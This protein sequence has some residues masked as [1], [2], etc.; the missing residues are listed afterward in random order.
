MTGNPTNSR[1]ALLERRSAGTI[2]WPG[3]VAMLAARSL[4]AIA[5]QGITAFIFAL[6]GSTSPWQES[7]SWLPVY[8]TLVDLGCLL[9]L[10]FLAK[11]EGIRLPDLAGFDR[12]RVAHHLLLGLALVPPGLVLILAGNTASSL[13]VL[14]NADAPDV[15]APIP[16]LPA[17]YSVLIFPLLWAITEQAT[18][19]GYVL[20]RLEVLSSSSIVAVC[21]VAVVW[22]LQHAVMPLTFDPEFML[23]RALAPL[24][25]SIF[26]A[27]LYLRLRTIVPFATAHWLMDGGDA[28]VRSLLPNL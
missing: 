25:F 14:G 13:L 15:F 4:L 23:Y 3:P 12:A 20:P 22:W 27:I 16:L 21:A 9:A 11:R 19:N 17:L 8:G 2:G 5:A 10:A 26:Q 1:E 28:F 6:R 24:P 7:L 18:Y